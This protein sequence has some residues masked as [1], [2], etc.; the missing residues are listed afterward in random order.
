V[1][2]DSN[3]G[4]AVLDA[5][6]NSSYVASDIAVAPNGRICVVAVKRRDQGPSTFYYIVETHSDDGGESWSSAAQVAS[7][8][9]SKS[10]K[11]AA[12]FDTD[13]NL[14]IAYDVDGKSVFYVR[15]TSSGV[16]VAPE[17]V[18]ASGYDEQRSPDIAFY[19]SRGII[20]VVWRGEGSA[21]V[22]LYRVGTVSGGDVTWESAREVPDTAQ[23]PYAD[24]PSCAFLESRFC[25]V[26]EGT[27]PGGYRDIFAKEVRNDSWEE[28]VNVSDTSYRSSLIPDVAAGGK[29]NFHTVWVD[30][31]SSGDPT[32]VCYAL[33]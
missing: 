12:C 6:P 2:E 29:G 7:L 1:W 18:S 27:G 14:H 15:V 23:Y 20:S 19:D 5:T 33:R 22:L 10:E 11:V 30:S 16:A 26:W 17:E 3:G 24:N 4:A 32:I 13:N 8:D 31:D 9:T 28:K 21:P 25:V